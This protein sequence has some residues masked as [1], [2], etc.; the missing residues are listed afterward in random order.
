V[1]RLLLH[2]FSHSLDAIFKTIE[3]FGLSRVLCIL[4]RPIIPEYFF[5]ISFK[6][7]VMFQ[8]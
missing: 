6:M 4:F 3:K 8:F 2:C 1:G 7:L 5:Q